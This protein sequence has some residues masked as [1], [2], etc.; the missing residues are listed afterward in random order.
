M[1]YR[2]GRSRLLAALLAAT[3]GG[4]AADSGQDREGFHAYMR[5]GTGTSAS[6]DRGPQSCYSLGGNTVPYRLG[7]DCDSVFEGGYTKTVAQSGDVQYVATIWGAAYSNKTGFQD[8][9]IDLLK[10]YIEAKGLD[11][12][13]G[14]TAWIGKRYYNRPSIHMM[15]FQYINFSGTGAGLDKVGLGPGKFSYAFFKDNDL[16]LT[17]PDGRVLDSTAA[18]RQNLAYQELPVNA[19]GTIDVALSLITAQGTEARGERHDGWQVSVFHKQK[20]VLGGA[21]TFGIQHGVGPG[22]GIGGS[23]GGMGA[24]GSTLLGADVTRTR[25]LDNL[26][27]QPTWNLGMEMIALVQKDKSNANGSSTWMSMGVRPVYALARHLKLIGE[28]S[29]DR[30]TSPN[31]GPAKRL[32]KLTFAPTI[33]A[34]PD[35]WARPELRAFVTYGR[36]NNAATASVNAANNS[37]PVY[38][39][40]TS[41]TSFGFHAEAW[42]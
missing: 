40:G 6:N 41:G 12:L 32:T 11:F 14:G 29:A 27:I 17:G 10:G 25:M 1:Y 15:D 20:N 28:F 39:N 34:G 13:R 4:A 7:N 30:V 23:H 9:K 31:G 21:N 36:W 38:N 2:T 5:V 33:A 24:S 37:G 26:W 22:T 18:I 19:G 16:N 35:L 8:A 42:F 3:C